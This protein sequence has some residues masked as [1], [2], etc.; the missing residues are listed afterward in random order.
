MDKV[1]EA[2]KRRHPQLHPLIFQRSIEKA[3]SNGE[4]FD[5]LEGM[6]T[7][8]PLVWDDSE[9]VWKHTKDILQGVPERKANPSKKE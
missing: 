6:P 7:D 2:L 9:R 4:L 8:Y 1:Q 3:H 5:L